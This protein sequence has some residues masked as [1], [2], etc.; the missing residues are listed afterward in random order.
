M[1][2]M[3]KPGDKVRLKPNDFVPER[4]YSSNGT[5][6][7]LIIPLQN[8]DIYVVDKCEDEKWL[9]VE[10]CEIRLHHSRFDLVERFDQTKEEVKTMER[11]EMN[12]AMP[13]R[14]K[15]MISQPMAGRQKGEILNDREGAEKILRGLGYDVVNTVF[16]LK[17]FNP[18]SLVYSLSMSIQEMSRCEVVYFMKGWQKA[19]GCKIEHDIAKSYGLRVMYEGESEQDVKFRELR[20]A[21]A[22][23]VEYMNQN[24]CPHDMAIVQQDEVEIVSGQMRI[25]F[26]VKD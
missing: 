17:E 24:Y 23:L 15:A 25:G 8:R 16:D 12:A 21:A 18:K 3:F 14:P 7:K 9:C 5:A 10:G 2:D 20:E 11:C 19:R 4:G 22:P 13:A 6:R 26:P 1:C